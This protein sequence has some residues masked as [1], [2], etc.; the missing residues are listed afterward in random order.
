MIR[1]TLHL[2][3]LAA[4][5]SFVGQT[6]L[7][8][9]AEPG[10]SAQSAHPEQPLLLRN[11]T[12]ELARV[13]LRRGGDGNTAPIRV[14]GLE[15]AL[16]GENPLGDLAAVTL[17]TGTATDG[18]R[19]AIAVGSPQAPASPLRLTCDLVLEGNR[20]FWL[21]G[22]L[23][24]SANIDHRLSALCVKV[25]TTSSSLVPEVKKNQ[26][27]RLG[28]ALRRAGEDGVHTHRIPALATSA[29]GALLCVY[30]LRRRA[31]RDLQEDIDIGL[32][33][34]TDGGRTWE[35]P[36]VIMDMGEY[37]GLPQ[38]QN[39]CS[40]PGIIVDPKTGEIFV[41]AVW[42]NGKTG[43]H[44]WN[45]D[46]SEAGYAIGKTAQM[47]VV[48]SKDDGLTWSQPENLTRTLK[49]ESWVLLAPSPQQGISLAN[50]TLVMPVQGRDE[51]GVP[52][53]TIMTSTS[54]GATWK[55]GESAYSEGNEC[56]AAQ[57][58]DGRIMLNMRNDRARFRAV[59][60][61]ADL[62][63][64]WTEHPTHAKALIEPNC[65]ASLL[66]ITTAN[67]SHALLFSNPH[68]QKTRTRQTIQ[69]SLDDGKT[70]PEPRHI[71][72]DAGAGA[73]Y[74]S[75]TR[76]DHD[77]IGIVYEGSQA[78]LVFQR[79]GIRELLGQ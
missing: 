13:D 71:L 28:V 31:G 43:K 24:D 46:G 30:D 33:R 54:H 70:W 9:A 39:G 76:I 36:R 63:K 73:G 68:T 57:L 41:F 69:V 56:Q 7:S 23:K 29:P 47:L 16:S 74:S 78:Q 34:S 26:A 55:V 62:G 79:L 3:C 21:A 44:Q 27:M 59:A 77:H 17:L 1:S 75:M 50:G 35:K 52:F 18:F 22:R 5:L 14:T 12:G 65:N 72:L 37:G 51:K 40:D 19:K 45:G 42:M 10:W 6:R 25:V 58:S 64:T 61:T 32:S 20:T 49:K 48:R 66:R 15:F 4:S 2:F 67:G 8:Q 38:A 53:A 11:P 60:V